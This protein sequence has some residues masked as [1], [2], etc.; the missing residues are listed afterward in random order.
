MTLLG[1]N[2]CIHWVA[3]RRE[4]LHEVWKV[5]WQVEYFE[6]LQF[7]Q[8]PQEIGSGRW[9]RSVKCWNF[10]I[11]EYEASVAECTQIWQPLGCLEGGCKPNSRGSI[12]LRIH[13]HR[14]VA[15]W[16][17]RACPSLRFLLRPLRSREVHLR[18]VIWHVWVCRF[19]PGSAQKLIKDNKGPDHQ[20]H[21]RLR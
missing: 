19:E 9:S 12:L 18:A 15:A 1:P 6:Y 3:S 2:F 10:S 20:T 13:G 11:R 14:N 4:F 7:S 8:P 21:V 17:P 5:K 16:G